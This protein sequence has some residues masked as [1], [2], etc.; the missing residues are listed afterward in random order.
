MRQESQ[1]LLHRVLEESGAHTSPSFLNVSVK[2]FVDHATSATRKKKSGFQSS[3][4]GGGRVI[5]G[6]RSHCTMTL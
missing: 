4:M 2:G 3:T 5:P 1:R 6:K